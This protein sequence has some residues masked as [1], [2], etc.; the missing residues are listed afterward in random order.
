MIAL[1]RRIIRTS[2]GIYPEIQAYSSEGLGLTTPFLK[3]ILDTAQSAPLPM[4]DGMQQTTPDP[5]HRM[6]LMPIP[7]RPVLL[8]L[9]ILSHPVRC[10]SSALRKTGMLAL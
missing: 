1:V 3:T 9:P 8:T 7:I 10:G 4:A 2:A 5:R 6:P